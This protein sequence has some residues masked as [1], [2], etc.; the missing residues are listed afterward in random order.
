MM[1]RKATQEAAIRLRDALLASDSL[2]CADAE[3]VLPA[4]VEAEQA[5]EDVDAQPRFAAVLRHLEQCPTCLDVYEQM[6]EDVAALIG[7]AEVLPPD[8]RAVAGGFMVA[9]QSERLVLRVL[10]GV[11]QFFEFDIVRPPLRATGAVLGSEVRTS[12]FSDTLTEVSGTPFVSIALDVGAGGPRVLVAVREP[13]ASTRWRVQL[14]LDAGM[15][16]AGTDERGI[17]QIDGF[18][19]EQLQ[20]A[21]R[22]QIRCVAEDA[23]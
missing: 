2:S 21:E 1:N 15:Y 7:E 11:A 17:A 4:L 13:A 6:S 12:L 5:G 20:Q 18:T 19:L 10:R 22:L 23:A 16:A 9:R 8:E 3:E 14:Q